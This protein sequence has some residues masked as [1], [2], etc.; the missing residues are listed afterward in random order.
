MALEDAAGEVAAAGKEVRHQP[1]LERQQRRPERR[2]AVRAAAAVGT[3]GV[4]P[5]KWQENAPDANAAL[6]ARALRGHDGG[7]ARRRGGRV[8]VVAGRTYAHPQ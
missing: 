6:D 5:A 7:G 4:S 8:V 2:R 3:G 1:P